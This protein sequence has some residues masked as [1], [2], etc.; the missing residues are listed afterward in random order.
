MLTPQQFQAAD[1]VY[2]EF[3]VAIGYNGW[4]VQYSRIDFHAP[5]IN[6]ARFHE[7]FSLML[8]ADLGPE[9]MMPIASVIAAAAGVVAMMFGR[10]IVQFGRGVVGGSWPGPRRR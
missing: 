5:G 1:A 4:L 10:S 3:C 7:R 8:F 6:L 9:T 2:Y